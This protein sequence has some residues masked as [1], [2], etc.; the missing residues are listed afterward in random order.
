MNSSVILLY[1]ANGPVGG[2]DNPNPP[3]PFTVDESGR[4]KGGMSSSLAF[5][6]H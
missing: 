5:T 1:S 4:E 6:V 3:A 2:Q